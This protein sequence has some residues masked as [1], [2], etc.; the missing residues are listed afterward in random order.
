MSKRN[1]R[2]TEAERQIHDFAVKVR[3]MTDQ[4]LYD[5]FYEE[6]LKMPEPAIREDPVEV[7]LMALKDGACPGIGSATVAKIKRYWDG[8]HNE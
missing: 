1:C 5:F 2:R 7:L 6:Q 3:K 4:Q 8:A